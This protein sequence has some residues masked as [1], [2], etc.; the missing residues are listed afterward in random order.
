MNPIYKITSDGLKFDPS[1]F[2][3]LKEYSDY[4]MSREKLKFVKYKGVLLECEDAD[5]EEI[6]LTHETTQTKTK[7]HPTL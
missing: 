5:F 1:I 4:V 6:K 2:E 3:K 7:S